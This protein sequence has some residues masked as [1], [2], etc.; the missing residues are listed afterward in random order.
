MKKYTR[1]SI[2][3]SSI[4]TQLSLLFIISIF[5]LAII[6][7]LTT[8]WITN[9]HVRDIL[10]KEGLKVTQGVANHSVLA[11]LYN[12][13]ENANQAVET[14]LAFHS[15]NYVMIIDKNLHP[16]VNSP[17]PQADLPLPD[18]ISN[19]G[20]TPILSRDTLDTWHFIAPVFLPETTIDGADVS[21][22]VENNSSTLLGYAYVIMTKSTLKSIRNTT[23]VNNLSIGLIVAIVLIIAMHF[24]L[25][26]FLRPL[27]ELVIAME[28]AKHTTGVMYTGK[29]G[30]KET[31][32]IAD[33]FNKMIK[34]IMERDNK[35]RQ[36]NMTLE[37]E[38]SLRTKELVHARD[39][40][41]EAS[42]YKSEFLANVSH[43]LR[44]PLQS[45]IGY[46]DVLS[47]MTEDE[48]LYQY[49]DDLRRITQNSDHLLK[50]IN[51]ILDLSKIEAGHIQLRPKTTELEQLLQQVIDT[52][53][54]L[55]TANGNKLTTTIK[56]INN[57]LN[58]DAD[59]LIQ[60]LLNIIGNAAKFTQNGLISIDVNYSTDN[61]KIIVIDNGIGIKKEQHALIFE[62]FRQVDGSATRQF[63]GTGLGL[64]ISK[65][66][67]ELMGGT[68]TVSSALEQGTTFTI[69]IPLPIS[70]TI[71]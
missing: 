10:I 64:S 30:P 62:P 55:V 45:I 5:M 67:C 12:S 4:K 35:L 69:V 65:H 40:A 24:I 13:A 44:T 18:E 49:T 53:Y 26:H 20:M 8:A 27:S 48:G 66:F 21:N 15:I 19:V 23:L 9:S 61:L 33:T 68:I 28:H 39:A 32:V 14:A 54:P 16:L 11:L 70:A 51:T 31:T 41:L 50:L 52:V 57:N 58:I 7:S 42:R 29:K 17:I 71:T 37:S 22:T 43:E 46:T 47:E 34:S 36:Q 59:K 2:K 60:I 63:Q 56:K 1:P 25:K 6:T 3:K 38:V